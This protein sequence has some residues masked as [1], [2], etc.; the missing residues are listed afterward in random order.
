MDQAR[1]PLL[2]ALLAYV[3]RRPAL[4][5]VPGHK[6][7]RGAPAEW[8]RALGRGA[9]AMDLTEAPGLDDLHAPEGV[10]AEAQALAAAAFGAGRS[11]FL[12]GG[13]T[14]G[15]Q[16]LLLAV[17]RPGDRVVVPR[18]AHR[19]VLAGLILS[20][21]TPVY[22][23]PEYDRE[24]DIP[25]GVRP[26]TLQAALA[27]S[28]PVRAVVVVHPTYHGTVL[29]TAGLVDVARHHGAL[30]LA[31]EAHGSHFAFH[32]ALPVPALACGA[33]AVVQ[34][35]HKTGG[36]L[37]QA[38]VLHVRAGS[39]LDPARV[40]EALRWVQSSSPSYLLLA[41][42]DAARRELALRG[43]EL[44]ARALE[45]AG[46]A[47][48]QINRLPGLRVAEYLGADPTRLVIDVRG[49]RLTGRTAASALWNQGVAVE[50]SGQGYVLALITPGDTRAT[51]GRLVRALA[52]LPWGH[53]APEPLGLPPWPEVVV[54]PREAALGEREAVPLRQARG[55]VAAELVAPYPPGVPV[56][57]PGEC[58]TPAVIE[59]LERCVALGQHLQGP[60]DPTLGTIHVLRE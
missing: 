19:S 18:H 28:G 9:L 48:R 39:P 4:F 57:A 35:L 23:A 54:P 14:A 27:G 43:K 47:R 32:P 44:W 31:D 58:I 46:W 40:Q 37:T 16:A 51:V 41:S 53:R 30:V 13:T 52:A 6:Q 10:I 36:A 11:Y 49:R 5:H 25:L 22:V 45:L 21:A 59:Y 26:E 42:L 2:E 33:D 12:V 20:G 29:D 24:L 3:A 60:A 56:L 7:G 38:S 17:C 1:A 50:M 15:L 34:S 55:R 8:R